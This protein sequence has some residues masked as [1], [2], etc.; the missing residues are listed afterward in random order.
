MRYCISYLAF[1]STSNNNQESKTDLILVTVRT[2][3]KPPA[4]IVPNYTRV[5]QRLADTYTRKI[6]MTVLS[7]VNIVERLIDYGRNK[8]ATDVDDYAIEWLLQA[9]FIDSGN[10][11]TEAGKSFL[12]N[13]YHFQNP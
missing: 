12:D 2:K 6:V 9:D 1:S 3:D 13:L 4:R 7:E 11:A 10:K 5:G 8:L